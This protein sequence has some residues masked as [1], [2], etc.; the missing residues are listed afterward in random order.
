M[1]G[2]PNSGTEKKKKFNKD[3]V[4]SKDQNINYLAFTEKMCWVLV[5]EILYGHISKNQG[6]DVKQIVTI[7]YVW[8]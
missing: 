2:P 5:Y 8:K 7:D 3:Y 6:K 4:I 1:W